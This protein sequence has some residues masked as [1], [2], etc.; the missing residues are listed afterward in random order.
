MSLDDRFNPNDGS[1]IDTL[2]S[3]L[4]EFNKKIATKWQDKTYRS[5]ADLERVLYFGSAATL[6]GYM[7]NTMSF[8]MAIPA[9]SMALRGAVET[10]RPKSA[11]HEEIQTEAIGLPRKTWKYL[12]VICYGLGVVQTLVGVGHLV[13]GAV[14]GNNQLYVN[15]ISHLT[16]GL[17]ILG[18]VSA[19]YMAKS[20][21]GTPPPKPKKKPVLE[22]IKEKVG[23]LLPQ[24]TPEPVSVR[25]YSGIN[26]YSLAQPH[27]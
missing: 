21:I 4:F 22:R 17:G 10:L 13:A 7:T 20:D 1:V 14:S 6:G 9:A 3:A 15:S 11:K 25:M 27:K 23:G 18:W 19:D 2:D 5:K 16:L 12:N 24:P 8:I 26:S